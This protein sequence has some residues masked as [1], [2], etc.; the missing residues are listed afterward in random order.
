MK[1]VITVHGIETLALWNDEIRP[2]LSGIE[3]FIHVPHTYGGGHDWSDRGKFRAWRLLFE[4]TRNRAVSAFLKRY[5]ATVLEYGVRPSIIAHSFGTYVIAQALEKY[6]FVNYDAVILCGSIVSPDY[7][8]DPRRVTRVRNEIAPLDRPVGLLA[9]SGIRRRIPGSGPSGVSG[10]TQG[11]GFVRQEEF[12][13]YSHSTH[14]VSRLHCDKYWVPFILNTE[15]FRDLCEQCCQ[16]DDSP[17]RTGAEREFDREYGPLIGRYVEQ[18]CQSGTATRRLEI[19][20]LV[21]RLVIDRGRRGREAAECLI[22]RYTA[23]IAAEILHSRS[24]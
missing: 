7:L 24:S 16:A 21:R 14:F 2:S 10:F 13:R 1:V 11:P 8:W 23:A 12:A 19:A 18:F 6:P 9:Y 17:I 22:R 3:D 15:A 4:F 20:A 5:E